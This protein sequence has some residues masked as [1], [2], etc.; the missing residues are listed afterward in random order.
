[1]VYLLLDFLLQKVISTSIFVHLPIRKFKDTH[2][3]RKNNISNFMKRDFNADIV[4]KPKFYSVVLN[5][6]LSEQEGT[7]ILD[8]GSSDTIV[9]SK[10]NLP[11]SSSMSY[12]CEKY[13]TFDKD[14]STTLK[15]LN[16]GY[17]PHYGDGTSSGG[18]WVQDT[19]NMGATKFDMTFGLANNTNSLGVLGLGLQ[20]LEVANT[21]YNNFPLQ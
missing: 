12:H 15:D 6:G 1:M 19:I 9:V 4:W 14:L 11:C 13:D 5:I 8:T 10:N 20:D 7:L 17:S 21:K 3:L 18:Q 2:V 16:D